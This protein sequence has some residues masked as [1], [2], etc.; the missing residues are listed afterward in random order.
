MI[1]LAEKLDLMGVLAVEMFITPEGLMFNEMAPRP[2]NSFHWTIE[3][4]KTSQFAQLVRAI[5][6]LPLGSTEAM[7]HWR[8]DNILGQHMDKLE[9]A[10]VTTASLSTAMESQKPSMAAKWPI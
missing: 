8:M 9:A 6:G 4:T 5:T 7:G 10:L 1:A 2:H 3:G